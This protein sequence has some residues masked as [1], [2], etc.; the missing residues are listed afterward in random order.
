[1]KHERLMGQVKFTDQLLSIAR[2]LVIFINSREKAQMHDQ[3]KF[4]TSKN[5]AKAI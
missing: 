3:I 5:S 1:M 4:A 2:A